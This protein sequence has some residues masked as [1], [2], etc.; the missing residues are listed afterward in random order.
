MLFLLTLM[1]SVSLLN[2]LRSEQIRS[3]KDNR[4]KIQA[5]QW[6]F[7]MNEIFQYVWQISWFNLKQQYHLHGLFWNKLDTLLPD[8]WKP[9]R[10]NF[11]KIAT[12]FFVWFSKIPSKMKCWIDR[13]FSQFWQINFDLIHKPFNSN[14]FSFFRALTH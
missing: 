6:N 8:G 2:N 9:S 3:Q 11:S 10:Q 1:S 4:N 13:V 12:L 7:I 5:D 14:S